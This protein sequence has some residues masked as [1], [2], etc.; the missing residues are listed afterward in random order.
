MIR[1]IIAKLAQTA[2]VRRSISERADLSAFKQRPTPRIIVGVA[3][4]A[5]S[6]L[7]GW[8]VITVLGIFSIYFKEPMLVV[9]G[10]PIFYG[11]SHLLFLLGMYLAGMRYTW[12]F[13]RWLT[14]IT[15]VKLMKKNNIPTSSHHQ[16]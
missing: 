12:I 16:D 14:R 2:F 8:P 9:I 4:I 5:L 3:L 7:I 13:L 1:Y 15:M 11:T 6:Y 10:G